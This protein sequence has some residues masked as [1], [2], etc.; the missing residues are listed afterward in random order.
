MA[1]P[2]L[3]RKDTSAFISDQVIDWTGWNVPWGLARITP[4]SGGAY[5]QKTGSGV[6]QCQVVLAFATK[7]VNASIDNYFEML[8]LA[9]QE[10][11][12]G[13]AFEFRFRDPEGWTNDV[14]IWAPP[15]GGDM[16]ST[17]DLKRFWHPL[18]THYAIPVDLMVTGYLP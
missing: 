14:Q 5:L 16:T 11:V 17:E 18:D 8:E 4:L 6:L 13:E 7:Y 12:A 15:G 10:P 9:R 1:V 2:F 3:K